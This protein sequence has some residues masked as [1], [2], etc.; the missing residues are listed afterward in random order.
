MA[1]EPITPE[2]RQ[3]SK[4]FLIRLGES[5]GEKGWHRLVHDSGV[6]PTTAQGWRV[7]T[8]VA[9]SGGPAVP[10][11]LDMLR[12]LKAAGGLTDQVLEMYAEAERHAA[13]AVTQAQRLERR[14]LKSRG[15]DGEK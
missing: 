3:I 6:N 10:T 2:E 4:N 15:R 5:Y 11:G 13:E 1:R 7:G 12:L 9:K 14:A 8:P